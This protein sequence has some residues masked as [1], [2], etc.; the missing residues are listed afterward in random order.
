ISKQ[1]IV[2]NKLS[3]HVILVGWSM[4]GSIVASFTAAARQNGLQIDLFVGLSAV[5]PIPYIMQSGP[6]AAKNML[7]S[8]LADR[9][10]IFNLFTQLLQEQSKYNRH[11]IIPER[12]YQSQFLG[13]IPIDLL[14]SGK[15]YENNKFVTD[16]LGSFKDAGTWQFSSYPW[17]TI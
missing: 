5:P 16:I 10:P 7:A 15:G 17:I 9:K 13:N 1:Y 12:I 14:A 4:G 3:N 11:E 8:G 2:K 6:Y